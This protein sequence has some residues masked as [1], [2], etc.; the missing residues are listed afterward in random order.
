[1]AEIAIPLIALGGMYVVA[2]S[3]DNKDK[4]GYVNMGGSN[5]TL[6]GNLASAPPVNYCKNWDNSVVG[7]G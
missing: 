1:M 7:T 2:N 6:S 4:E 5:T 3:N